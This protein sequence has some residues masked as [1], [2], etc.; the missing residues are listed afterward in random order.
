MYKK[1]LSFLFFIVSVGTFWYVYAFDTYPFHERLQSAIKSH[2]EFIPEANLVKMGSAGFTATVADMYWLSTIQYIGGNAISGAYHA[3]LAKLLGLITDLE[4]KLTQAYDLGMLL[5]ESDSAGGSISNGEGAKHVTPYQ[6]QALELGLKGLKNTCDAKKI[7]KIE[8]SDIKT[9]LSSSAM[10][11]ACQDVLVPYYI[12][13]LYYWDMGDPLKAAQ[14][15]KIAAANTDAPSGT[16]MLSAIMQGKGGDRKT[17]MLMFLSLADTNANNECGKDI[18]DLSQIV[19]GVLRS[20]QVSDQAILQANTVRNDIVNRLKN[21][22]QTDVIA[23]NLCETYV[24]KTIRELNLYYIAQAD[25]TYMQN[26]AS[27]HASNA[28]ILFDAG[29]MPTLPNDYQND[30]GKITGIYVFNQNAN[31]WEYRVGKY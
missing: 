6:K 18:G 5:L 14:Y 25:Q 13:Y 15:Y 23:D 8:A 4:P 28:K 2:P 22:K 24:G 27:K 3:Y 9:V 29:Y 11:N 1:L 7:S 31:E 20:D 10:A 12:A 19:G 30:L 16:A 26:H 21:K 17:A